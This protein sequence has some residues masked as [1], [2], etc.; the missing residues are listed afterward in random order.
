[1]GF[2]D[3]IFLAIGGEGTAAAMAIVAS[4]FNSDRQTMFSYSTPQ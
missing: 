1:M 2:V 4:A 3:V